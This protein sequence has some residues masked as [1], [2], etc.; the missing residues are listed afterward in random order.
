[1]R[2][3]VNLQK[4]GMFFF[5]LYLMWYF[6]NF[7]TSAYLYLALHGSYGFFWILKDTVFPDPNFGRPVTAVSFLMPFPVALI[8]YSMLPYWMISSRT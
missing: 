8:P 2:V 1:M 4:G 7:T 3:Y 6:D 5:I